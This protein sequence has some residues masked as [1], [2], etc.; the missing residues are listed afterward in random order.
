MYQAPPE[1]NENLRGAGVAMEMTGKGLGWQGNRQHAVSQAK[2][3]R[4]YIWSTTGSQ[5]QFLKP[6]LVLR[7]KKLEINVE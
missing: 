3:L 6:A 4:Y 7:F 2:V 1:N 5:W